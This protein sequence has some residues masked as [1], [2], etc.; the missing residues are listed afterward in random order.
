ME[1]AIPNQAVS[2]YPPNPEGVPKDY[3]RA[4]N[5]Y[6]FRAWLAM[7]GLLLF[8]ACYLGL[9][10]WFSWSAYTLVSSGT[11]LHGS[12]WDVFRGICSGVIALFVIKGLF[13]RTRSQ[14]SQSFEVTPADQ[15]QLFEFLYRLADDIGAPRPHKVFLS[16]DVNASVFYDLSLINFFLPSKKNLNIGLGLVNSLTLDEFKAVL[17]H[18]FGHFAQNTMAV[19][20]WVY[21][22]QRVA[23]QLIYGRDW[24]DNCLQVL[25]CF[26]LRIAWIG[27][28]LRLIVWAIRSILD[29]VLSLVMLAH[30]ALSREMEFQADLVAVSKSGSDALVHGLFKLQAADQAWDSAIG[31]TGKQ[32][33]NNQKVRDLFSVQTRIL[34]HHRR[35]L[36]DSEYGDPPPVPEA[37][38]ADHRVFTKDFAQPPQMWATHP[39]N[40]FREENAKRNY[41]S[42]RLSE[43][44]AWAIFNRVDALRAQ[45]TAFTLQEV[46]VEGKLE[47]EHS[48]AAVDEDYSREFYDER[49]R[50]CYLGRSPADWTK[51]I[52]ELYGEEPVTPQPELLY[53]ETLTYELE[54]LQSLEK[55]ELLLKGLRDRE[56]E[57]PD[58][59]IRFRGEVIKRRQIGKAL[60]IVRADLK[61]VQDRVCG[62][63]RLV[64]STHLKI[65]RSFG[66]GWEE[67]LRGLLEVLHYSEHALNGLIEAESRLGQTWNVVVADGQVTQREI[68]ILSSVAGS[69]FQVINSVKS[70]RSSIYLD[71]HIRKRLGG[72]TLEGIMPVIMLRAPN[73]SNVGDWLGEMGEVLPDIMH[74]LSRLKRASLEQLLKAEA[75]MAEAYTN[76]LV[77][78]ESAPSPSQV[79]PGY[80]TC[81]PGE[82]RGTVAELTWWDKFQTA[83][84]TGATIARLVAS[85]AILALAVFITL[86]KEWM[87]RLL[88]IL[89]GI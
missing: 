44:S 30:R 23:T 81:L 24:L 22:A 75:T 20:R 68:N 11:S 86:P 48:I 1:D 71:D 72:A 70:Y 46:E 45:L 14:V 4:N 3:A 32:I 79:K 15:P 10:A 69:L 59:I 65:A 38:A 67:Y 87:E 25:S 39:A 47:I 84:G 76:D 55:E 19:G 49:Y 61:D 51:V 50:G 57:T 41:I 17:A 35:I 36:N 52:H 53:P 16:P 40:H 63:D 42:V 83:S 26:D 37:T 82:T 80:P 29:S 88:L 7:L 12:G 34:E 2:H 43:T 77:P 85:G 54:K 31:F 21:T 74:A 73:V 89:P 66:G 62:H 27:W 18:E 5:S 78:A 60:G 64:R 28:I 9:A 13:F 6:R 33:E 56:F 58:G 8:V